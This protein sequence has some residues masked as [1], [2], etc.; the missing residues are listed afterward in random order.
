MGDDLDG[1]SSIV[2]MTFLGQDRLIDL[3]G[4]N[5]GMLI[6]LFIDETLIMAKIQIR[7]CSVV[8]NKDFPMLDRRHRSRI[9][10]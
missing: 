1:S 8:G 6:E 10:I 9:H 5:I 3:S 2:A 4:R 7:L